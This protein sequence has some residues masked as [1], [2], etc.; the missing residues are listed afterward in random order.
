MYDSP[1]QF[2]MSAGYATALILED[3]CRW[4]HSWKLKY[5]NTENTKEPEDLRV[6][7]ELDDAIM[8]SPFT[9]IL[10]SPLF[11][12]SLLL[13]SLLFIKYAISMLVFYSQEYGGVNAVIFRVIPFCQ[14]GSKG[15][16]VSRYDNMHADLRIFYGSCE[17]MPANKSVDNLSSVLV[18]F[19]SEIS[20]NRF[21]VIGFEGLF[22]IQGSR[23][24]ADWQTIASSGYRATSRGI[25][26]LSS[27]AESVSTVV[28][29]RPP[30]PS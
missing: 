19:D 14:V 27:L 18:H 7:F 9:T 26:F 25:R 13:V 6:L 10:S 30:W 28:D 21:E 29:H 23:N 24:G 2:I 17:I 4:C 5:S 11:R 16:T 22:V 12:L 3:H 15:E 1:L 20:A 8:V